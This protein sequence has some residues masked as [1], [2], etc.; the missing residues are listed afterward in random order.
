MGLRIL[1]RFALGS[2]SLNDVLLGAARIPS[3]APPEV[4][5]KIS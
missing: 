5:L 2:S 3:L 1:W 4:V